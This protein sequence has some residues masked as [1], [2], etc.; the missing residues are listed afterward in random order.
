ML[1]NWLNPVS[2]DS[3]SSY[4]DQIY[5][6]KEDFPNLEGAKIVIFT[7]PDEFSNLVRN[8]M[9][10]L[11][12]H[13]KT[14]IVDIGTLNTSNN[15]SIFQVISELQDGFITPILLGV[16]QMAF[17]DFCKAMSHESK[18]ET[19][20]LVSNTAILPND[21]FNLYNIGYQRHLVP[22]YV[23]DEIHDSVTPGLSLGALRANQK[24]LEPILREVNY[25]HFDLAAVRNSDCPKKPNSIPTGLYAEEACQLMRYIGEG[26]RLKF[27]TFDTTGLNGTSEL[28]AMLLA[29]L[30]WYIHEGIDMKFVDHPAFSGDF[31]EFVIELNDIDHSL[32][33]LQSTKSGKWWLKKERNS[34]AYI[35]C[36][37]EEY[38]QSINNEIPDRLLKLL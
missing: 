33:F 20:A 15:S 4:F 32:I 28:A 35:S 2:N 31:K 13:F 22:K 5:H 21:N 6:S 27:I 16:N 38:E 17:L 1:N 3:I 7:T 37:Y 25:L 14:T 26:L 11:F 23:L 8:K 29:E 36:A 10:V 34:N 30:I 24:I 19:A 18:L 9:N 12:N